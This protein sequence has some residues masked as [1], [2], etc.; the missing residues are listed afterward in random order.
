MAWLPLLNW[1]IKRCE[2][3]SFCHW[4]YGN[5]F[6][7]VSVALASVSRRI[8][9]FNP[10]LP[11]QSQHNPAGRW[12]PDSASSHGQTNGTK[13]FKGARH[14]KR[15]MPRRNALPLRSDLLL[16]LAWVEQS[17]ARTLA[18]ST[19]MNNGA[20]EL[21]R[22]LIEFYERKNLIFLLWNWQKPFRSNRYTIQTM[23]P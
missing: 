22:R 16:L 7:R 20:L 17:Y 1:N 6:F 21:E 10:L 12:L 4:I 23:R 2:L 8:R 13:H 11:L 3:L 14:T 9:T 19:S 5:I 18:H 15:D